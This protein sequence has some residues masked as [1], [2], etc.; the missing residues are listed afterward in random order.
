MGDISVLNSWILYNLSNPTKKM[1]RDQFL[2]HTLEALCDSNYVVPRIVTH[3][4]EL[5]EGK[6]QKECVVCSKRA[7]TRANKNVSA[8][9]KRSRFWCAA[10]KVGCHPACE[11]NLIH[12]TDR[13]VKR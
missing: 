2:I 13:G 10:C 9:R 1:P 11:I 5:L 4:L 12:N 7:T 8:G 3:H 6:L